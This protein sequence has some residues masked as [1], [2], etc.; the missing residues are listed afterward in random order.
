MIPSILP[1]DPWRPTKAPERILVVLVGGLGDLVLG[2]GLLA[3]LKAK[4]PRASLEVVV[5]DGAAGLLPPDAALDRW[6]QMP[7]GAGLP[8]FEDPTPYPKVKGLIE[9][10]ATLGPSL[11]LVPDPR[12]SVL[13]DLV[14]LASNGE[15]RIAWMGPEAG[16]RD[17]FHTHGLPWMEGSDL[18]R[19]RVFAQS[20]GLEWAG[21]R[22]SPDGPTVER[23]RGRLRSAGVPGG[24]ILLD[25]GWP[26]RRGFQR[27]DLA[28]RKADLPPAVVVGE[29][30]EG[31]VLP[32][33]AL[34]WREGLDMAE[35]TALLAQARLAVGTEGD[36]IHAAAA[37]GVPW[38]ALA[39]GGDP[40]RR[41][42]GGSGLVL[43]HPVACLGCRWECSQARI[44]C[45]EDPT[46]GW[47]GEGLQAALAGR[48]GILTSAEAAPDGPALL[49][50]ELLQELERGSVG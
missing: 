25:A 8:L 41:R 22:I 18:D 46:P 48:R 44:H 31:V 5:R 33:G 50:P 11:V 30:Q 14:S 27:W 24:F 20:L 15:V 32:P 45:L 39:G 17:A 10:F 3:P 4:F 1:A 13:A 28:W 21:P 26:V 47:V 23:M 7:A 49:A 2:S 40:Q 34:D 16:E 29:R 19:Y 38:A 42:S 35:R 6:H 12:R 9:A 37:L 36:W 43:L